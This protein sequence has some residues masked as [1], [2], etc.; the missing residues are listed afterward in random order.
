MEKIHFAVVEDEEETLEDRVELLNELR[1]TLDIEVAFTAR[2]KKEFFEKYNNNTDSVDALI[3]DIELIGAQQG[4]LEI[5]MKVKKPVI[6]ISG[7]TKDYIN[8]IEEVESYCTVVKHITKPVSDARFKQGI[9]NFCKEIRL[10]KDTFFKVLLGDTEVN[11]YDIVFIEQDEKGEHKKVFYFMNRTPIKVN[12]FDFSAI[13]AWNL[14]SK[15][16]RR[17]TKQIVVNERYNHYNVFR[18]VDGDGKMV[19]KEIVGSTLYGKDGELI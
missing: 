11:A 7:Y 19:E 3:L 17:M 12:R 2:T 10:H 5:A 13:R 8:S 16:F 9:E 1:E 18:Y 6:F 4:G 15:V 14:T